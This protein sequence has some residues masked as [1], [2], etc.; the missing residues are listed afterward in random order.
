MPAKQTIK[1]YTDYL[2]FDSIDDL[3][4]LRDKYPDVEISSLRSEDSENPSYYMEEFN[5]MIIDNQEYELFKDRITANIKRKEDRISRIKK[6]AECEKIKKRLLNIAKCRWKA[7]IKVLF[8]GY[9]RRNVFL[10]N[11]ARNY[12]MYYQMFKRDYNY[13][14]FQSGELGVAFTVRIACIA[15]TLA[16]QVV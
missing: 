11:F 15:L 4:M 13:N 3:Y 16:L 14:I 12:L 1:T 6:Q 9:M 2:F 10:H 7:H 5:F 8:G